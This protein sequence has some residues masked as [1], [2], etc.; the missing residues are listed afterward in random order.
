MY[1]EILGIEIS[2]KLNKSAT[3]EN[4]VCRIRL[5]IPGYDML[6]NAQCHTFEAATAV[7]IE[8]LE[9]QIEKRKN[10]LI[11]NRVVNNKLMFSV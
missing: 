6:A 2:L 10:K 11:A 7:A 1:S 4:K 3:K 9:R 8:A 5:I